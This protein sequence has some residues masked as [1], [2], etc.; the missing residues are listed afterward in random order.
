MTQSQQV[1]TLE[2]PDGDH[3]TIVTHKMQNIR[4]PNIIFQGEDDRFLQTWA[5]IW[6]CELAKNNLQLARG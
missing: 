1:T 2:G 6:I 5:S 3:K 4:S